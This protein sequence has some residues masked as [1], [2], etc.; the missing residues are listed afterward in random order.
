MKNDEIERCKLSD[1]RKLTKKAL[2]ES[3]EKYRQVVESLNEGIWVIDK[4]AYTTFVN[5]RMAKIMG[6]T[7]D[8]ML[9]K[10]LFSFMDERRIEIAKRNLERQRQG[11]EE[12]YEFEL[13]RKDGVRVYALIEASSITD[14]SGDYKGAIAAVMDITDRKHAEKEIRELS[15]FP[16]ENPNPVMRITSDG[17][18]L[19]MNKPSYFLL[20]LL[21]YKIG[22]PLPT[23]W[24]KFIN[25]VINS[26]SKQDIDVNLGDYVYSLTFIPIIDAGYVNIYG[27]DITESKRLEAEVSA[28]LE[29]SRAVLKYREF[30][31]AVRV[32]FDSYKKLIGAN[33]GYVALLSEDCI[34]NEIVLLDAGGLPRT[35]DPSLPMPIRGLREKAYRTGKVVYDNNF[36]NSEWVQYLPEGHVKLDSVLF[37]PLILEDKVVGLL[38]LSHKA[39]GFTE[40]DVRLSSAFAE[41]A[42]IAFSNSRML[43]SLKNS[44]QRYKRLFESTPDGVISVG[45]DGIILSANPA[46]AVIFGYKS[47]AE[48]MG[49]DINK[50]YRDPEHR[51]K[52][53]E[54]LKQNYIENEEAEFVKVDGSIVYVILS[55][56]AHLDKEGNIVGKECIFKDITSRKQGEIELSRNRDYLAEQVE[57]RTTELKMINERL[58][59]E[60]LERKNAEGALRLANAYNRSLIEASLDPLVTIGLDGRITDVNRATEDAIG[61][62]REQLIGTEFSN[63]F[64]KPE[65]A[66]EGYKQVFREGIVCDYELELKH[67]DGSMKSVLY[68]AST[69]QNEAGKIIGVFAAA[70]DITRLKQAEDNFRKA[71]EK[72]RTIADFTYN[73]E[74][75]LTPSREPIYHSPSCYRITGQDASAFLIDQE[76]MRNIIITDDLQAWDDHVCVSEQGRKTEPLQFRILHTDGS[77]RW[78]EHECQP[79]FDSSGNFMGTRGSNRDITERKKMEEH[80]QWS[81]KMESVGRLSAG[82]AHEIGNPLNSI[83]SLAQLLQMRIDDNFV[84]ENLQLMRSHIDRISRIVRNLVDL[85]HPVVHDKKLTQVND[86]LNTAV[87]ILKYDKRAKNIEFIMELALDMQPVFLVA[88]QLLQVFTNIIFNAFGAMPKGGRL[89]IGAKEES[90]KIYISFTDTGI[91]IKEDDI[92]HIFDPFFTTKEIGQG[93]GLGLSISYGFIKSFDGEIKVQSTYGSGSTFTVILPVKH[94]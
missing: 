27:L 55:I 16:E 94:I 13:I 8:E 58:Q 64:T 47:P 14:N 6:Y 5:N 57:K 66:Q 24:Q 43:E 20:A 93:T 38:G 84:K 87:D 48:L 78:I 92:N 41:F 4:D 83:S 62:S 35:V 36:S 65:K 23:R 19:Y 25:D 11:I 60:N 26:G 61:Y 88:D 90:N 51:K 31:E 81:Q 34:N 49:M 50:L 10:N 80:L 15:K 37:A 79:V 72:Y 28:L 18:I 7:V 30:P 56:I 9:G 89:I 17:T 69:Y 77:E 54:K 1:L 86:V 44:E 39:D 59:Q 33:A 91:G 22:D 3:E 63:Y 68:N 12:Q 21:G 70:R 42:T 52:I 75:W 45:I 53:L 40:K 76:L 73:W 2:Q 82:I 67:Q 71:E 29:S 32:I 46:S 85:A 74:F